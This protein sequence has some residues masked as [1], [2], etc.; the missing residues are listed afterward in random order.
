M[1]EI[2]S[3][4]GADPNGGADSNGGA[5]PNDSALSNDIAV[6]GMA[7]RFPDADNPTE[8]WHNLRDGH[9]SVRRYDDDQLRSAGIPEAL[10]AD[11]NY[12]KSGIPLADFDMFDAD[13]FGLGPKDASVMDPQHRVLLEVAWE[14][15][16]NTGHLPGRFDG[17]IGVFAGCGMGAYFIYNVLSNPDLVHRAGIFELRHAGNDKDF[18]AT[19]LSYALDLT[20]PSVNVQTACSTS[21]V[22]IHQAAQS[23]LQYECDMALAGGVTI[24]I[25]HEVGY[26][27][28]EGEPLS[29]DGHCRAFDHRSQ[30]TVFGSGAGLVAMRRLGDAID[31]GDRI[32]AVVKG[33]AINN[34]GSGKVSFLA[35]SVTGQAAAIAEALAMAD[36]E[37]ETIQYVEAHGTGTP[38]GDPIEIAALNDAFGPA[39]GSATIRIGSVK[40][41]IG[42]LDTA[43]GIAGFIKLIQALRHQQIPP[44]INFEAPN[45]ALDL[46]SGPFVVNDRLTDWPKP[47]STPPRGS[48]S[49]LGVGGTNAHVVVEAAPEVATSASACSRRARLLRVSGRSTAAVDDNSER[50]AAFL[51]AEATDDVGLADAAHSLHTRRH[52]F[53][54]RRTV[55][56]SSPA[57]AIERL[58]NGDANTAPT[59]QLFHEHA[60][61]AFLFPG[62]GTQYVTMGRDLYENEAVFRDSVDLGLSRLDEVHSLNLRPLM[63]PEPGEEEQAEKL[64]APTD[65]QLPAIFITSFA[66]ARQLESWGLS[67]RAMA[68]HSLGEL[69]AACVAGVFSYDDAL[70]LAVLRGQLAGSCDGSL[71]SVQIP[72]QE[73]EPYLFG[74]LAVASINAADLVVV[75]GSER[76]VETLSD[77]LNAAGVEIREI[78]LAAPAH[79]SLLEPV[80]PAWEAKLRSVELHEPSIP[81]AS[82]YSGGWLQPEDATDP[83]YWVRQ[84]RNTVRFGDNA[85]LLLEPEGTVLLEVGPGRALSS[86]AKASATTRPQQPIISSMRHPE[87]AVEDDLFLLD[88]VGRLWAAGVDVDTDRFYEG[89]ERRFVELPTYAF[90]H[91]RYFLEPG[92][93]AA[94]TAPTSTTLYR[95]EDV[96]DWFYTPVWHEEPAPGAAEPIAPCR[97]LVFKDRAGISDGLVSRLEGDGHEVVSVFEGDSFARLADNAFVVAPE[98][99]RS[100]YDQ[101]LNDLAGSDFIPDRVLH[102][103]SLTTDKVVRPGSSWYHHMQERGFL[104]LVHLAQAVGDQFPDAQQRWDVVTNGAMPVA[105]VVDHP[106]KATLVGPVEVIPH[107]YPG[108]EISVVDV[109]VEQ[110]GPSSWS[111]RAAEHAERVLAR[112]Q[113][114][115]VAGVSDLDDVVA[116]V[117]RDLA[118]HGSGSY[119][120]YRSGRRYVRS[121]D[122]AH[123]DGASSEARLRSGGVYMVTGG[124]GGLGMSLAD[125]LGR[126]WNARLVLVGRAELPPRGDWDSWLAEHGPGNAT[127]KRLRKLLALEDAG[128]E[129]MTAS[130]DVADISAMEDVVKEATE[131]FGRIDGVLHTAG[132]V[133][134]NLIALK[135]EHELDRVLTPKVQGAMVLDEVMADTDAEFIVYFSSTSTALGIPGQVDYAAA[136]AFLDAYGARETKSGS[137]EIISLAWGPWRE[138]G[139]AAE[140]GAE[141]MDVAFAPSDHPLLD[142]VATED[143]RTVG[144][145]EL[146]AE[147]MWVLDEHRSESGRAV[148]PGTGHLELLVSTALE[149]GAEAVRVENLSFTSPLLVPDGIVRDARVLMSAEDGAMRARVETAAQGSASGWQTSSEAVLQSV[150]V[151]PSRVDLDEIRGRCDVR[152]ESDQSGIRT[153]QE[154]HI[155]FGDRWRNLR[156]IVWGDGEALAEVALRPEF[157]GDTD[158]FNVH[159]ALLDMATGFGLPLVDGYEDDPNPPLYVPM[160]YGAVTWHG[161]LQERVF[162]HLRL[163]DVSPGANLVRFDIT[164][165]DPAGVVL[166]EIENFAIVRMAEE[167]TFGEPDGSTG[168][169]GAVGDT[170]S[171]EVMFQSFL[172]AGIEPEEGWQAFERVLESRNTNHVFVSPLPIQGQIE[173]IDL[174]LTDDDEAMRFERPNL[175]SE[176]REPAD[177]IERGLVQLWEELLGVDPIGVDDD[178]FELGGH[179]LVAL[180]LF[181]SIKQRFGVDQPMS[182]LFDAS[183]VSS[184]ADLIRAEVGDTGEITVASAA[185]V[186]HAASMRHVVQMS[187]DPGSGGAPL[188]LVAGM[189]GNILNLRHLAMLL[190]TDRA[191]YGVQARGLRDDEAPHERFED[192][193]TAYLE[194]ITQV[195]PDGPYVL[196]GF[197]GGGITAYEMAQQ[198]T[199]QG[200]EVAMVVMLDTP[201]PDLRAQLNKADKLMLHSQRLRAMKHRYPAYYMREKLWWKTHKRA[202]E[203][204]DYAQHEFRSDSIVD[205][206]HRAVA[207]YVPEPYAGDVHMYRPPMNMAFRI[208][209]GRYMNPGWQVQVADNG[210]SERVESLHLR[211][212]PGTHDSMVLEP[213]VRV[214]AAHVVADIAAVEAERAARIDEH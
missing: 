165:V 65:R 183:T 131:R 83:M 37:P 140:S 145:V 21:L 118:S 1:T 74:T 157:S 172:D 97:W 11:P 40:P 120:G 162:S 39:G 175:A 127:S 93:G 200:R 206:F 171:P 194:E 56:A 94:A 161:P 188:F 187:P 29:P 17:D 178:F 146:S 30:G 147:T 53:D 114:K 15:L 102:L 77:T 12:V 198:L 2:A 54:T 82:N 116:M 70:D 73:V 14:T 170:A 41:N 173:L 176:Y 89:Q 124:L 71:V 112:A 152:T 150:E 42:H 177:E 85:S 13:F 142:F 148:L 199:A 189:F 35:P 47:E 92:E 174:A 43:A 137:P 130:A 78:P 68:G 149:S 19:R 207:D 80:L 168:A 4:G 164:V 52:G 153:R 10:I 133:E 23:L 212:V 90:Q 101:L 62:G 45:P 196:G 69:T 201:A 36:V 50:L 132:I 98:S 182:V 99:G 214:L 163:R 16:E 107:E 7:G 141:K 134:E 5:D 192:M 28:R 95:S 139:L 67:P 211:E 81:I 180:R 86:F 104:S 33:S 117:M 115:D 55:V 190:G 48:I 144:V 186:E 9:E 108:I 38:L 179:S 128:V 123:L 20:G 96:A 25:P 31:D 58:R 208:T 103:W 79:S 197:S 193:A 135:T 34:D 213:N 72:A 210:W 84:F 3:N 203:N 129:Y 59:R 22:A 154:D 27:Y 143:D 109:D 202:L 76:D 184:L 169:L 195:H 166:V 156:S 24:E 60:S 185:A 57:E 155:V 100:G 122:R 138:V 159:P 106:E 158:H 61:L 63:Y 167:I 105:G 121:L 87:Q 136:N 44:S 66:M 204:R 113:G 64:L 26:Q 111:R 6:V 46:N 125:R 91:Q 209:G 110:A 191:V 32:L 88:V 8:F 75:S 181:A 51:E 126:A 49:S 18:L 205:A 119:V 151:A 160:T